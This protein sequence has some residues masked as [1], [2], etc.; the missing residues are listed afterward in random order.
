MSLVGSIVAEGA[1]NGAGYALLG[2]GLV[3]TYR[4]SRL[5]NFAHGEVGVV[6]ATGLGVCVTRGWL[7][8]AVA[9]PLALGVGALFGVITYGAAVERLRRAPPAMGVVATLGVSQVAFFLSQSLRGQVEP[10]AQFPD[11]PLLHPFRL[12]TFV[13]TAADTAIVVLALL[14]VAGA[15][16]V[17]QHSGVGRSIRAATSNADSARTLGIRVELLRAGVWASA[18]MLTAATATFLLPLRGFTAVAA[19]GPVL[20]LRALLAAAAGRMTSFPTT[21]GAGF[22]TAIVEAALRRSSFAVVPIDFVLVA[23]VGALLWW[24]PPETAPS[25]RAAQ[26]PVPLARWE[27]LPRELAELPVVRRVATVALMTAVG[28][29]VILPLVISPTAAFSVAAIA[30]VALVALSVAI[31]TGMGG[32]VSL[33]QFALAGVG[34]AVA[35]RTG[36]A[37]GSFVIGV[38]SGAVAASIVA[39]IVGLPSLRGS[40]SALPVTTLGFAVVCQT[41]LLRQ[42]W[43]LGPGVDPSRPVLGGLS[44]DPTPR[45]ALV[46]LAALGTGVVIVRWLRRSLL[47]RRIEATRDNPAAAASFGIHPTV[48]RA[49][50]LAAAGFVAGLGGAVYGH[51]LVRLDT[52]AFPVVAGIDVVAAAAV[53]GLTAVAGPLAGAALIRGAPL[54]LPAHVA[55]L[56]A[57]AVGWL[58]IVLYA[59]GGLAGM[60]QRL[61]DTVVDALARRGGVD[62][63]AIRRRTALP[64]PAPRR[65]AVAPPRSR[66]TDRV[67][68]MR[69]SGLHR[70]F[71]AIRAVDGVELELRAGETVAIVGANGAGKTTLFDLLSGGLLPDGGTVQLEGRD[72]TS[73]SATA[74]A[75]AGVVRT[76]QNGVLFPSLTPA[77]TVE[78]ALTRHGRR[79]RPEMEAAVRAALAE[80]GLLPWIDVPASRLST[81]LRRL[82]EIACLLTTVPKVLLLDEPSAGL[83]QP[84]AVALADVLR[85]VARAHDV[86]VAVTG[87]DLDLLAAIGDRTLRLERGHLA[88]AS[89]REP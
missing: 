84:E 50:A 13:V 33:G 16:L 51:L 58:L 15:V 49:Q 25:H 22:V 82:V 32:A 57:S 55:S 12:G 47:G 63:V 52:T 45:Y 31:V 18:G 4:T 20:L 6:A 21:L 86:A 85:H 42:R 68:T 41:W 8:Y 59:P 14:T 30:S 72:I 5:I 35:W 79:R 3:A 75:R 38:A 69:A 62:P 2:A 61:R 24:R 37:T 64:P 70:A 7:P 81:G 76:F 23:A 73:L 65:L 9:F 71:G 17:L 46:V 29:A 78:L 53:G 40:A 89:R 77:Q 28:A 34:A 56:A 54:L 1:V 27:P 26:P 87:H 39:V 48:V 74:R 60:G 11:P 66:T 36:L 88:C 67:A 83:A 19:V 44:F 43:A 10:G 80:T